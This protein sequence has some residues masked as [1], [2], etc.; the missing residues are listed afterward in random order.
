MASNFQLNARALKNAIAAAREHRQRVA[1]GDMTVFL[2][3]LSLAIAKDFLIDLLAAIPIVGLVIGTPFAIFIQTYLFIFMWGRGRIWLR[4]LFFFV[5]LFDLIPGLSLI[6][7]DTVSVL[8]AYYLASRDAKESAD[9]LASAEKAQK[10]VRRRIERVAG[11]P[12][13]LQRRA[14]TENAT[15][16][17]AYIQN[18]AA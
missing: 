2:F 6:P 18:E 1:D 13:A 10:M 5:G 8:F 16:N 17:S 4:V 15:N 11:T 7:F 14:V 9:A 12:N 3:P